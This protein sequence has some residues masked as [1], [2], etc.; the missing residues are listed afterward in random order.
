MSEPG[1]E[2]IGRSI[3]HESAHQHVRGEA[4]YL[5]DMPSLRGELWVDFVGSP[6]AHGRIHSIDLSGLRDLPGIVAY[7]AAD[8]PGSNAFGPIFQDE[9]IL[10]KE[11]CHYLGQPI[12]VIAGEDKAAVVSAKQQVR[13]EM[14]P[15]PAV[16]TLA[17][18]IE[19]QQFIGP[20]RRIRARRRRSGAGGRGPALRVVN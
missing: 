4:I 11:V 16:L 20:T 2:L 14:D 8:V 12:V 18:A 13:I 3:A 10:A 7:T 6:H 17:E 15:L 19:R 9:E 1:T 5:G